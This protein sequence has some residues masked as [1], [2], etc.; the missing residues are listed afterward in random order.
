MAAVSVIM[1][2]WNAAPYIGA[3]IDSLR[4]QTVADWELIVADDG[5]TDSTADIVAAASAA[6]SRIRLL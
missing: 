5:S 1:P 2:A 6:D 4:A 3:A